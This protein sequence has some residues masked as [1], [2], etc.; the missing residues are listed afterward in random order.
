[1]WWSSWTRSCPRRP[2]SLWWSDRTWSCLSRPS[3]LW[4]SS[5]TWSRSWSWIWSWSRKSSHPLKP[6]LN[7]L[8]DFVDS[9]SSKRK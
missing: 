8:E 2:C 5:G 9:L 3:S 4:R 6:S 7:H 1:L